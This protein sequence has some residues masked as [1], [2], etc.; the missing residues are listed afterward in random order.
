MAQCQA[1]S[2][3]HGRA[4]T[5]HTRSIIARTRASVYKFMIMTHPSPYIRNR[6]LLPLPPLI[7]FRSPRV[8]VYMRIYVTG[9]IHRRF[10]LSPLSPF[11][12]IVSD[13]P[14]SHLY[15]TVRDSPQ[16]RGR[17]RAARAAASP[18]NASTRERCTCSSLLPPPLFP[19]FLFLSFV[20]SFLFNAI[21]FR[22]RTRRCKS[23]A[24]NTRARCSVSRPAIY[25]RFELANA[26]RARVP[27]EPPCERYQIFT[28][29]GWINYSAMERATIDAATYRV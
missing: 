10:M 5:R 9:V 12:R 8:R 24:F 4:I 3:L 16:S 26:R 11:R 6:I 2:T 15:S 25:S 1:A 28:R 13:D 19:V 7:R 18:R 23:R 21:R 27:P 14:I 17:A 22:D 29:P 20:R